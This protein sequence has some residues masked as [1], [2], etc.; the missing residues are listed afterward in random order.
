MEPGAPTPL[1]DIKE[2]Q[3]K[4]HC[5][6]LKHHPDRDAGDS[7]AHEKAALLNEAFAL[8]RGRP[9]GGGQ[10]LLEDSSLVQSLV[11]DPV[12][13]LDG[14]PTYEQWLR[15]QFYDIK[16]KSIWSY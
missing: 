13:P 9:L 16:S 10:L 3:Y 4:Y 1:P 7:R 8:L 5:R 14:V 15:E 12:T 11:N 6:M 2:V